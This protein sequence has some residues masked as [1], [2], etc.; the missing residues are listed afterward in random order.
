VTLA[1]DFA[2]VVD[3]RGLPEAPR[4]ASDGGVWFAD[5]ASGGVYRAGPDGVVACVVPRRRGG[6]GQLAHA[7]GGLVIAGR[8]LRLDEGETQ[9]LLL[10]LPD[11][12]GFNDLATDAAGRVYAGA[13]TFSA[14]RGEEPRPGAIWRV[15]LDGTASAVA[16]GV[17]WPN[18]IGFSPAGDVMYVSDYED[19]CVLAYR[20]GA[21][22]PELFARAPHGTC[23]GLAVDA[24]G[25]VWVALGPGRGIARWHANG[26]LDAV[27]QL[28]A[29]FVS[30]LSFAGPGRDELLVT[31]IASDGGEGTLWRGR[32]K[33]A[34]LAIAPAAV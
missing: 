1:G 15:E 11:V 27:V 25:G 24:E 26:A 12:A 10:A 21:R 19:A 7:G 5:I 2:V 34:G 9:R 32:A 22:S 14:M 20:D 18:G 3:G 17:V 30:S 4:E 16:D 8:D 31:G 28:P 13:L 29:A 33:V 6:G 23:D